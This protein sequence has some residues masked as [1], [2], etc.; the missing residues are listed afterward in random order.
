MT[1][2]A[3]LQHIIVWLPL[4]IGGVL[5]IRVGLRGRRINDHPICRRCRFDLVGLGAA[6]VAETSDTALESGATRGRPERCP[7][8]GTSLTGTTRRARRAVI[9]GERKK[10][11]R[12]FALGV[13]L[14]L[15]GLATGFWLS[16]KPLAKFPWTTWMPDWVLAEM[17]DS[18]STPNATL[19]TREILA[20]VQQGVFSEPALS[21]CVDKF[22]SFQVDPSVAWSDRWGDVVELGRFNGLVSDETFHLY[23]TAGIH[24]S[25][26]TPKRIEVD[27]LL[28]WDFNVTTRRGSGL[29][30]SIS[31]PQQGLFSHELELTDIILG[32]GALVD[33]ADVDLANERPPRSSKWSV[34]SGSYHYLKPGHYQ[35]ELRVRLRTIE[36]VGGASG[37]TTLAD[38]FVG[39]P[40][41]FEV[42]PYDLP[43]MITDDALRGLMRESVG[44]DRLQLSLSGDRPYLGGQIT[45]TNAP[46]DYAFHV[47]IRINGHDLGASV[48]SGVARADAHTQYMGT[49]LPPG[50]IPEEAVTVVLTPSGRA[51]PSPGEITEIW[52]EQ[53][54]IENVPITIKDE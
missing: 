3:I 37:H 42:V 48:L 6:S 8:C 43:V 45:I 13:V 1:P 36:N 35:G 39:F 44:V 9:D 41:S 38:R 21:R 19:I 52:G 29:V 33:L 30:R 26:R 23:A 5:L 31:G 2:L 47:S 20:R 50:A 17:V 10:R 27:G 11:W 32:D 25:V 28:N 54:V 51:I 40:I 49:V 14:L 22:L 16:Y 24:V 4:V 46:C 15:S 53:I 18:Q 12:L 34:G 7:E